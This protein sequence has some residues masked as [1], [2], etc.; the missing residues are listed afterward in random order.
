M[1]SQGIGSGKAGE[2]HRIF[3]CSCDLLYFLKKLQLS[4]MNSDLRIVCVCVCAYAY[5]SGR[6]TFSVVP[7]PL[8]TLVWNLLSC[9]SWPKN[10]KRS[11]CLCFV[12]GSLKEQVSLVRRED[13][14]S[15]NRDTGHIRHH[16]IPEL[17]A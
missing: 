16:A 17:N 5:A 7:Q 12:L 11:S 4:V 10:L 9:L 1:L 15:I 8:S 14:M 13:L 3:P 6:I 2:G